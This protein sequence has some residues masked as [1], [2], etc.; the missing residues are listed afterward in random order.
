MFYVI[1]GIKVGEAVYECATCLKDYD[2]STILCAICW[3]SS[4]HDHEASH[5]F[6]S[7][8]FVVDEHARDPN[9]TEMTCLECNKK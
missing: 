3:T 4:S 8:Q 9:Q 5:R 7:S 6:V 2:Y 1:T